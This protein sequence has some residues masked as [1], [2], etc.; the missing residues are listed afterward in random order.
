MVSWLPVSEKLM[1]FAP[2][3]FDGSVTVLLPCEVT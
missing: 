2:E 3:E 1:G